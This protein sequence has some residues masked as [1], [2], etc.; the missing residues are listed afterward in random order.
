MPVSLRIRYHE[1]FNAPCILCRPE[2]AD[3]KL[4]S[5]LVTGKLS[6]P[7][8]VSMDIWEM[9]WKPVCGEEKRKEL[10]RRK[11]SGSEEGLQMGEMQER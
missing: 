4:C 7:C 2:Q 1:C 3:I 9:E 10:T 8:A 11:Y 5:A 6:R